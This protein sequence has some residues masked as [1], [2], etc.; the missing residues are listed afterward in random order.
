LKLTGLAVI[1]LLVLACSPAFAASG[2]FSLGYLSYDQST[3][4]C[5]YETVSFS[6][7]F[8]A[9]VHVLTT[10][11]GFPYDGAQVGFKATIPT[12]T[13]QPVT[14]PVYALA[15]NV[16]D[17]E[18]VSFSGY[19]ATWVTKSKAS[20][21]AQLAKGVYGWSYYFNAGGN[22]TDYLGNYGFLTA[23]LGPA[24]AGAGVQKTS[25]GDSSKAAKA[26]VIR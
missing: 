23:H 17:A 3:Q 9:G 4:Y 6:D 16:F 14:G 18:F 26:K 12:S 8:A 25:F 24:R 22:G 10:G 2:S 13:G 1:T 5:D 21:K 15:D 19:Q 11:C 20:T 7:P